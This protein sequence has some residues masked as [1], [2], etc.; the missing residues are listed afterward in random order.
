MAYAGDTFQL[1]SIFLIFLNSNGPDGWFLDKFF[2]YIYRE[3][4]SVVQLIHGLYF[5]FS[6]RDDDVTKQVWAG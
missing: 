5:Y 1:K 6:C 2:I 4:E 3:R